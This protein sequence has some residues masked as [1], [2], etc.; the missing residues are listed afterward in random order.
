MGHNK[1]TTYVQDIARFLNLPEPELY[2][3]RFFKKVSASIP[4]NKCIDLFENPKRDESLQTICHKTEKLSPEKS[5]N[6]SLQDE[7]TPEI[8]VNDNTLKN[9]SV[10]EPFQDHIRVFEN[11]DIEITQELEEIDASSSSLNKKD[12]HINIFKNCNITL[13]QK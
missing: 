1:I 5:V 13:I 10:N 4:S 3:G 11:Q 9:Q 7:I 6:E 2:T 12:R 8:S